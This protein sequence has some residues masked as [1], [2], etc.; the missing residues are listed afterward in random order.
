MCQPF[1]SFILFH[2]NDV[3]MIL[4]S[5]CRLCLS[6]PAIIGFW[7]L[8]RT[9]AYVPASGLGLESDQVRKFPRARGKERNTLHRGHGFCK[10][11]CERSM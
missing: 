7:R 8:L 6:T 5:F 11:A 3:L 4:V 9:I 1:N 2:P 10:I